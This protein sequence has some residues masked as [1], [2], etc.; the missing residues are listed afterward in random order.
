MVSV[1]IIGVNAETTI[2]PMA[3]ITPCDKWEL[4]IFPFLGIGFDY[5][6]KLYLVLIQFMFVNIAKRNNPTRP[7]LVAFAISLASAL[8]ELS[9]RA[10]DQKVFGVKDMIS[11]VLG[12][13]NVVQME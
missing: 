3:N 8:I 12:L 10:F 5:L 6:S 13:G 9:I 4:I 2:F 1:V 11:N 7:V